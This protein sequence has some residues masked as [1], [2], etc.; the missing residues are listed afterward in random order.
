MVYVVK[1]ISF[2]NMENRDPWYYELVAAF[3]EKPR[4]EAYIDSKMKE[5]KAKQRLYLGWDGQEYPQYQI[6]DVEGQLDAPELN[7]AIKVIED[8]I[9]TFTAKKNELE[10]QVKDLEKKKNFNPKLKAAYEYKWEQRYQCLY[11]IG[12]C[13]D[14][15]KILKEKNK[16]EE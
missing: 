3:N 12:T 5:L 11:K 2:D 8:K 1:K 6:E 13:E 10:L 4:A 15:L 14:M 16:T 9:K 7:V